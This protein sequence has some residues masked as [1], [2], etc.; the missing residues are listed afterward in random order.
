[1]NYRFTNES[2]NFHVVV[3]RCVAL[4]KAALMSALLYY[5]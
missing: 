3:W 4:K 2:I 5:L 1:M